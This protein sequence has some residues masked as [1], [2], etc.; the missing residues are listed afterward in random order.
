MTN[1]KNIEDFLSK[2]RVAIVGVS[3]D[4]RDFSRTIFREFLSRQYEVFPVNPLVSLIDEHHCYG[5]LKEINP[6][7]EAVLVMTPPN[8]TED[9]VHQCRDAGVKSVWF[10]RAAGAGASSQYAVSYCREH[11]IEVIEG[12]CPMMFFADTG[13][14]HRVHRFFSKLAGSYPK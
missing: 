1:L 7:V 2:R 4:P 11:H 6:P 9:V 10:Y 3:R 5:E 14:V 12:H 13:F 8:V